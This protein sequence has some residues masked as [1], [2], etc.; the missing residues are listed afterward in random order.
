MRFNFQQFEWKKNKENVG[1]QREF[2]R[3]SANS[4]KLAVSEADGSQV[5]TL[6]S[7]LKIVGAFECSVYQIN[8]AEI[9]LQKKKRKMKGLARKV[10][11]A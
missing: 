6:I 1:N 10:L 11:W 9:K 7:L 4:K 5:D 8:S 3:F 2:R